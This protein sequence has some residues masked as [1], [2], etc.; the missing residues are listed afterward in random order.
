MTEEPPGERGQPAEPSPSGEPPPLPG[1]PLESRLAGQHQPGAALPTGEPETPPPG[2]TIADPA[3]PPRPPFQPP[4][5]VQPPG[6]YPVRFEVDYPDRL[7]RWKT[8]LRGFLIIPALIFTAGVDSLVQAAFW[9][10][11][12]TVFFR[13]K[14][15]A[16]LFRGG[17]GAIAW[18]ARV[19]SYGLLLTDRYPSF[20]PEESPVQL[21]FADP[22][23]GRLSRWRVFFWKLLL[24]VPHFFVLGFLYIAVFAITVIAWF[25]ILITGRYPRGLFGFV[26]GVLRWSYRVQAYFASYN[27]RFP[28]FALSEEARPASR[29]ATVA[30]G[31]IGIVLVGGLGTLI[32]V[33]AAVSEEQ[34]TADVDYQALLRGQGSPVF[35]AGSRGNPTF[36]VRLD[37]AIDPSPNALPL[38]DA[39]GKRVVTFE[40]TLR[41]RTGSRQTVHPADLHLRYSDNGDEHTVEPA[42]VV[43]GGDPSGRI[44]NRSGDVTM[45]SVFVIP[46]SAEPEQLRFDPPWSALHGV[47]LTF[48]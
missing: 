39:P 47:K 28:P 40:W 18:T 6:R 25:A 22:P 27:D 15:P 11:W 48:R 9:L 5:G 29:G 19:A 10:G 42:L 43:V 17:A 26:T 31:I 4:P 20:A 34:G 45:Q 35:I 16:W 41:N 24:L 12:L 44:A 2:P 36:S 1:V 23:Q 13:R 14:Y 8:F 38:V 33:I 30:S 37:R 32:A 3:I 46:D 7:S 21:D